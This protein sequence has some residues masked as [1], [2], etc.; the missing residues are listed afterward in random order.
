[1]EAAARTEA[2][3]AASFVAVGAGSEEV[4]LKKQ[5]GFHTWGSTFPLPSHIHKNYRSPF[6]APN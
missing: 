4:G 5:K 3:V 2:A 6:S 1:M